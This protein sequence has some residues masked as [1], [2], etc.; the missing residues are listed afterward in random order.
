MS[1]STLFAQAVAGLV[2]V[3]CSGGKSRRTS[4]SAAASASPA[5]ASSGGVDLTGAGATFPYPIY[6]KWISDYTAKTGIKVNYQAIG[7]GGGIKGIQDQTIDFGASDAPMTDEQLA[8][9]KGGPI[10]HIPTALGAIVMTY[11]VPNN[12]T[13]L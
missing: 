2:S 6:Q 5:T 1:R 7:S 13:K 4:D 10:F 3:A 9:A 11:N 12:K 8:A